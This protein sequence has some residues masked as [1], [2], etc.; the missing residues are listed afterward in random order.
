MESSRNISKNTLGNNATLNQG[1]MT[2]HITL[3]AGKD[4]HELLTT[5]HQ[6]ISGIASSDKNQEFLQDISK[7]DP[8]YDKERIQTLKGPLLYDSVRWVL[9]HEKFNQ[10]RTKDSGILWINGDP[11]KGKT[12]LLCGIIDELEKD[13]NPSSCLG[14]FFCQATDSRINTA[15]AVIG[16]L[17]RPL[18]VQNQAL[19]SHIRANY[20]DQ[21]DG[22]N[23]WF[24]I[25]KIFDT[26]IQDQSFDGLTFVVDALDECTKDLKSLLRFIIK[27]SDK[28]KWLLSSRNEKEIKREL[29]SIE[30]SQILGLEQNVDCISNSVNIYL[31]SCIQEIEALEDDKELQ[32]KTLN[33]LIE[34]AEGTFLWVALVVEQLRNTDHWQVED[35]LAEVPAGLESLYGL[36][37][38]RA[39]DRLNKKCQDA[40]QILLSIVTTA[41]RPLHLKEL[42]TFMSFQWEHFKSTFNLD[43]IQSITKDCGSIL[44]IQDDTV[45]FI[46]QSAKDFIVKEKFPSGLH[47]QHLKMFRSSTDAISQGLKYDIYNLKTP[48][49][50]ISEIKPQDP[51]PLAPFKYCCLFWG[52]HLLR[53]YYHGVEGEQN[54]EANAALHTFLKKAFLCWVESIAL[55]SFI[56]QA[57]GILE[58]LKS[59]LGSPHRN[60]EDEIYDSQVTNRDRETQELQ[61]FIHDAY[62]F[63][64]VSKETVE[65]WPLQLYFSAIGFQQ[66]SSTI[67]QT[68]EQTVRAHWGGPSPTVAG[69]TRSQSSILV[70]TLILDFGREDLWVS[71][72][73]LFSPDSSRI[74]SLMDNDFFVNRVDTGELEYTMH[75]KGDCFVGIGLDMENVVFVDGGEIKLRSIE[76]SNYVRQYSHN[77]KDA[78]KIIALSPKGDLIAS[79]LAYRDRPKHIIANLCDETGMLR[80]WQTRTATTICDYSW[81]PSGTP[82]VIFSPNSEI[83]ALLG[84][85]SVR[86]HC[87]STG[88]L[89]NYFNLHLDGMVV[90]SSVGHAVIS[91]D[92][93]FLGTC[94]VYGADLWSIETGEYICNI[95]GVSETLQFLPNWTESSL[96]AV[97]STTKTVQIRR[98]D[99][100]LNKNNAKATDSAFCNI[101]ISP[102]SRFVAATNIR[103]Y[104][105]SIW[106]GDTGQQVCVLRGELKHG[107]D[108]DIPTSDFSPDSELLAAGSGNICIWRVTTGDTIGILRH[109]D[110]KS[111]LGVTRLAISADSTYLVAVGEYISVWRIDTCQ[112]VYTEE[113]CHRIYVKFALTAISPNSTYVATHDG[114]MRSCTILDWRT[115]QKI[116]D[117]SSYFRSIKPWR[118]GFDKIAFSSDS[119]NLVCIS[120]AELEIFEV[121]KGTRLLRLDLQPSWHPALFD[122]VKDMIFTSYSVIQKMGWNHWEE[123]P[124]VSYSYIHG[125]AHDDHDKSKASWIVR[126]EE[127]VFYLPNDFRPHIDFNSAFIMA[128]T[129]SLLAFKNE[130][131]GVVI[132]KLPTQRG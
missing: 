84:R 33:I 110:G 126:N 17:I 21:F 98:V 56:P 53:G 14:Y 42:Y 83:I 71:R 47:S 77:L 38:K 82:Q 30:S 13:P 32:S 11:G 127:K 61:K 99:V 106:S 85:N 36:I 76:D 54:L 55:M 113:F 68:F 60:G 5:Y 64:L 12:M 105:I 22:P 34:K 90:Q 118:D 43:D 8:F 62:Q 129:E 94:T 112:C 119:A 40:C 75:I 101:L 116:S 29:R 3:N 50:H 52:Q 81:S 39:S 92:S 125:E 74:Y 66:P 1:N 26:V 103:D 107:R 69:V 63:L 120:S 2:T 128:K 41:E 18:L 27:T 114:N 23:A 87:L 49:I 79:F 46:H 72:Q 24:I 59:L 89:K 35:V 9:D 25:C 117:C 65:S 104:D 20:E 7:T 91:P 67:R 96:I 51:D 28:V 111:S 70:E 44:S 131:W 97:K 86:I 102:D 124:R 130:S 6:L 109:L 100:N 58:K 57:L 108:G 19:L 95:A 31:N 10:W 123:F 122:P 73:L 93:A 45:Y 132:I 115:G 88:D 78:E 121:T 15:I 80:I 4:S 48:G 16:G 37:I